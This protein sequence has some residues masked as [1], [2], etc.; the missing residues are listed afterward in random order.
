M[1]WHFLHCLVEWIVPQLA[2]VIVQSWRFS[3]SV[4][5]SLLQCYYEWLKVVLFLLNATYEYLLLAMTYSM[6]LLHSLVDGLRM[7]NR[8]CQKEGV[9]FKALPYVI[10][11]LCRPS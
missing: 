5:E 2:I 7:K 6:A 11:E 1:D 10:H 9:N 3:L 4:L 8:H